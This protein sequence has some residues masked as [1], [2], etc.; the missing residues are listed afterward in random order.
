MAIKAG[1]ILHD[2]NGFVIDRIQSAGPGNLNI[3]QEK[4][5]ELGNFQTVA[6][7]FDIPDLSFDLESLDMSTEIE[8]I[9]I[10]KDPRTTPT[11]QEYDFA[12]CVPINVISPFKTGTGV[13]SIVK[14]LA[15]PFL[16]LESMTARFGVRQNSTVSYSLKG[17]SIFYIPGSPYQQTFASTTTGP[18]TLT[19]TAIPFV[20]DAV[21]QYVLGMHLILADGTYQR[22]FRGTDYT[23]TP[24]T[25][26]LT[27]TPPS[28][29]RINVVYGSLTAASYPQTVHQPTTVKP[30]AIRGKDIDIYIGS[31]AATP[32]FSRW[33]SVQS[34]ELNWRVN[35]D[36][37]EELGN[38]QIVVQDYDV[39]EVDGTITVRS[40]DTADLWAKIHQVANVATTQVVSTNTTV[41]VPVEI[42]VSDPES[43][44]RLK[45]Y[46]VSDA[47][48]T[49]PPIQGR[50]QQKLETPFAFSSDGG[51]MKI[52]QGARP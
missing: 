21:T 17:D 10:N 19:R 9:L 4:I 14:G 39:A 6:T 31:A 52:Y 30:A 5:Y 41:S 2:V 20:R 32:V 38:E 25:F 46:Y 26:T 1:Q 35:L 23:D 12:S 18:Y 7:I 40:R 47:R 48:F 50:V 43:G 37:D 22:L 51:N 8:A 15:V 42:R 3:P 34:A 27:T 44:T 49:L 29:S 11:G 33:A 36:R 28:S 13:F 16:N 24:T 45:T